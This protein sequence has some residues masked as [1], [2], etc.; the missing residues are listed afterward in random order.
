[1]EGG[2]VCTRLPQAV[3]QNCPGQPAL[4]TPGGITP[5]ATH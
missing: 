1:M 3:R 5:G 4:W 2:T